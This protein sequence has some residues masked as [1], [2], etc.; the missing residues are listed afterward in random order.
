M[1]YL[2]IAHG[3][4]QAG[5]ELQ[6][7]SDRTARLRRSGNAESQSNRCVQGELRTGTRVIDLS[8]L[9]KSHTEV[10]VRGGALHGCAPF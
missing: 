7:Q 8:L 4:A 5:S 3:V 6:G 1:N 10:I 9:C 2:A